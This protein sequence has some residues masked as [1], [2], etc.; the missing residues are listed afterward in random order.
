M[1]TM[2]KSEKNAPTKYKK[3][4]ALNCYEQVHE[5]LLSGYPAPHVAQYVQKR[6]KEYQHV[7]RSSMIL[8]LQ[9]YRRDMITEGEMVQTTLPR[10]FQTAEKRFSNKMIELERLEEIFISQQYRFDIL[11]AEERMTGAIDA[12]VDRIVKEMRDTL[13]RMHSIKM[14][15][16]LVGSRDLGTLTISAERLETIKEKYGTGAARAMADP[17]SRGRVLAALGAMQRAA[18]LRDM[19]GNRI[20][21]TDRMNLSEEEREQMGAIDADFE[22]EEEEEDI[23]PEPEMIDEP[24]A[25]DMEILGPGD[26]DFD[27]TDSYEDDFESSFSSVKVRDPV[28]EDIPPP[29]RKGPSSKGPG[30]AAPPGP[31]KARIRKR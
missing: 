11:H 8:M 31:K 7:T 16:G 27:A 23:G 24:T 30:P 20:D 29:P 2:A 22:V 1:L 17:V 4:R 28:Q 10:I 12:Q 6:M 5:M 9:Q 14:D 21:L 18:K 13:T 26:E 3:I 25:K 15:L 19:D